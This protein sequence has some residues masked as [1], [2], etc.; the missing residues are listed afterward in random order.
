MK[1]TTGTEQAILNR[2]PEGYENY[3]PKQYVSEV[4]IGELHTA[5]T[6]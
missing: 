4:I 6:L 3:S 5:I 1:L 2:N